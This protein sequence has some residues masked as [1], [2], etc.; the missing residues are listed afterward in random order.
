M[1]LTPTDAARAVAL[2]QDGRSQYYASRIL[3]VT[4]CSVQRAVQR[5]NETGSFSRRRGSGRRRSTNVR[6]DRFV[7]LN[8]L[9]ER[10]TTAVMARNRLEEVRQVPVNEIT[11]RRRLREHG[12]RSRRP[13]TVPELLRNPSSICQGASTLECR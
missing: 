11:I 1:V 10:N 13:A 7:T 2:V 4:R 9:R 5:F 8:V 3:G 6:D 12:L